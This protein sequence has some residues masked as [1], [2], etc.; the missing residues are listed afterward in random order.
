MYEGTRLYT[1]LGVASCI[2][3]VYL[4]LG[5]VHISP[6][7]Q[8]QMSF[9]ERNGSQFV[10]DGKTMYVNGWNSYW[11]M[12][13]SVEDSARHKTITMLKRGAQMG[14]NVVRTWAFNDGGYN[15]LQISPG[16]FDE[17]VFRA[18]D[19]VIV[20]SRRNRI[21]LIF[22]LVNNLNAYGGKSQYVQ[23]AYAAG[24]DI[25]SS[26]DSFFYNPTIR[27]YYRDYVKTI[28]TRKNSITGV[29]YRNEPAIFAWELINEPRC[30]S[31]PSGHTLQVWIEEMAKFVK[32]LDNKHLLTVGLEG[33]YGQIT[34]DKFEVN[35][36]YWAV[37]LG[38]DFIHNSQLEDI[39][40]ASVHAYPDSWIP[41]VE[42]EDH[43]KYI[44]KW[45]TSH[46]DDG[47][48]TL[49]KP[50]LFTEFGLSS[51]HKG[52]EPN[53]RDLLFKI[54]YDKIYESAR[55]GGAGA[56]AMVWQFLAEGMEEYGDR[57]ALVPWQFPSTYKLI[58]E[59]SCRLL[60]LSE[61]AFIRERELKSMFNTL[62]ISF[63][64][65]E[66][67]RSAPVVK[68]FDQIKRKKIVQIKIDTAMAKRDE[69]ESTTESCIT[70]KFADIRDI[71]LGLDP[72]SELIERSRVG[73]TFLMRAVKSS[74]I[75][76]VATFPYTTQLPEFI[77]E[78]ARSY[79]PSSRS[80]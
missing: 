60:T 67:S 29:E 78:C 76:R 23:W 50:V 39:D 45:A 63:E 13:Q 11:L 62:N 18:L 7:W 5:H 71:D 1:V 66:L 44:S 43:L 74:G 79:H 21:R 64:S 10:L 32:S 75:I 41:D 38:S 80:V 35:P 57:F 56:G 27:G 51:H 65:E 22:S 14:L 55:K 68:N 49:K 30:I 24:I 36:G 37:S 6:L 33:F 34:P 3:F 72:L 69:K 9:V 25:R 61:G 12:D 26:N 58:V 59:Q 48:H 46:I 4:N 28:L 31:D 70:S 73:K 2:V 15:A 47:E 19:F 17:R 20:E 53:H 8:T 42:L 16:I 54:M 77:M 52:F 40:F